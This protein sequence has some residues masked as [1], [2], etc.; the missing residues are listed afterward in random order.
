MTASVVGLDLAPEGK[1]PID[2]SRPG[3]Y[4]LRAFNGL[5]GDGVDCGEKAFAEASF[6]VEERSAFALNLTL[7]AFD[8]L[9]FVV[10]ARDYWG[11]CVAEEVQRSYGT[12]SSYDG[13]WEDLWDLF[14][15]SPEARRQRASR[16]RF[17]TSS[18]DQGQ[19]A[20]IKAGKRVGRVVRT[21]GQK[22]ANKTTFTKI[23][24]LLANLLRKL[25]PFAYA[26]IGGTVVDRLWTLY[27]GGKSALAWVSGGYFGRQS[28]SPVDTWLIRVGD[29]FGP[30]VGTVE[31]AGLPTGLTLARERQILVRGGTQVTLIGANLTDNGAP[32][33]DVILASRSRRT[34]RAT[35]SSPAP[36]RIVF[37][38]PDGLADIVA[39]ELTTPD[40]RVPVGE[41][42]VIEP[43]LTSLTPGYLFRVA[44]DGSGAM[45]YPVG[46]DYVPEIDLRGQGFEPQ[47]MTVRPV[48]GDDDQVFIPKGGSSDRR[49]LLGDDPDVPPG[50]YALEL[51]TG[52]TSPS[53]LA[54]YPDGRV[55]TGLSVK[56]LGPPT[57]G[58]VSPEKVANGQVFVVTGDNFGADREAVALEVLAD[59]TSPACDVRARRLLRDRLAGRLGYPASAALRAHEPHRR[60][61]PGRRALRRSGCASGPQRARS[62]SACRT[63]TPGRPS[64]VVASPSTSRPAGPRPHRSS[65]AP[66]RAPTSLRCS[67]GTTTPSPTPA[68]RAI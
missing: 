58:A 7:T 35:P 45:L 27:G 10:D 11:T 66:T 60:A 53:F 34:V 63:A 50:E 67:S 64:S 37:T 18:S 26:A 52:I 41:I 46:G 30:R 61:P 13:S 5:R 32:L 3:L 1:L 62:S 9:A 33:G 65:A 43:E 49:L 16:T 25:D 24:D 54:K 28:L 51:D 15:E 68:G 38:V 22:L 39:V 42:L 21:F 59:P 40:G 6:G 44:R 8:V 2:T 36:D 23:D 19:E 17:S 29:P 47:W 20:A 56:I 57:F 14:G 31:V 12:T 55:P 48:G 4:V